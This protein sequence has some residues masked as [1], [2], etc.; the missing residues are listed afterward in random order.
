[1]LQP[2]GYFSVRWSF[3]YIEEITTQQQWTSCG[4]LLLMLADVRGELGLGADA[5][6]SPTQLMFKVPG[7][8]ATRPKH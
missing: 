2:V 5:G 6:E 7:T 1:M 3:A 8:K 4:D